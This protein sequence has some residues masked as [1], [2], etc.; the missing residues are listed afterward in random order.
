MCPQ[1]RYLDIPFEPL[2]EKICLRGLP[3]GLT[4][5]RLYNQKQSLAK[6]VWCKLQLICPFV[7]AYAK[8]RFLCM[9]LLPSINSNFTRVDHLNNLQIKGQ[10]N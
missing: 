1:L 10:R 3:L 7:F 8:S 2:H 6:L 5:T 9:I 4:Q